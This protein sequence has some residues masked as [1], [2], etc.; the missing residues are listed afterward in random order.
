MNG[1]VASRISEHLARTPENF[2]LCLGVPISRTAEKVPYLYRHSEI[3]PGGGNELVKVFRSPSV[4][5]DSVSMA[6]L[7]GKLITSPHSPKFVD[8]GNF[9]LYV[10]GH[11]QNIRPGP[12]LENGEQALI[13]DLVIYDE[14][15]AS[16]I[17]YGLIREVSVAYDAEYE[18]RWGGGYDQ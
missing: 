6:S 16:Q 13:A 11:C 14:T 7:E 2:L 10:K 9:L 5:F 12:R 3:V 1:Y 18:E 4:V 15:L 17:E 8:S